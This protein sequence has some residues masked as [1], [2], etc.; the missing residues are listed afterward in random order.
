LLARCLALDPAERPASAREV[1]GEIDRVRSYLEL[2]VDAEPRTDVTPT[3]ARP[4][5][6]AAPV[7]SLFL[8]GAG[9]LAVVVFLGVGLLLDWRSASLVLLGVVIAT[10]SVVAARVIR[11]RWTSRLETTEREATQVLASADERADLTR[12]LL[13]EV[14]QL[15]GTLHSLDEKILGTTILMMLK[16]YEESKTAS[17]RQA[18]LVHVVNLVERVQARRA[19]WY[20]RRREVIATAV[21]IM[22]CVVGLVTAVVPLVE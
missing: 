4:S 9:L 18:A 15:V 7:Q 22:G 1:I 21:A 17:D 12:S 5:A 3:R 2:T 6:R 11:Q 10:S 20:V 14:D 16:E 13:I 19:P 8:V